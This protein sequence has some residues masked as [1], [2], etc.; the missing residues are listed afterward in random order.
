[1]FIFCSVNVFVFSSVDRLTNIS[2]NVYRI[3]GVE[4]GVMGGGGRERYERQC[5][6]GPEPFVKKVVRPDDVFSYTLVKYY[7]AKIYLNYT[8]R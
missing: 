8:R 7:F 4:I 2:A 6:K 5:Y 1:M 3:H